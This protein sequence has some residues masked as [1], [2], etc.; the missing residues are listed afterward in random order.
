ML[1]N[2]RQYRPGAEASSA[3]NMTGV[4]GWGGGKANPHIID[5]NFVICA[6]ELMICVSGY[7]GVS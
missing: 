2:G 5:A 1:G 6:G 4:R 7:G 3:A